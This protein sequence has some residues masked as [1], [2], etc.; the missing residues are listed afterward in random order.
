VWGLVEG[1]NIG[2]PPVM[3]FGHKSLRDRVARDCLTGEKVICLAIT[4]PYA[5]SDVAGLR[6]EAKKT[7]DGKHYIV[8][9]EKKWITNGVFADYF[10]VAVRTGGPGMGGISF[11]LLD[12]SMAGIT[13]KQMKCTGVWPSGTAYITLE[14]VK[15][16]VENLIGKEN[17]G[18]KY[19]VKN[20]NHERWGFVVQA[21]RF[22]RCCYEDAFRYAHKRKVFG[23]RLI[24]QPVI[25]YKFAQM[26]RHI[27]GTQNWLE[28]LTYQMTKMPYAE[29][30][31]VLAGPV[32]LLKA[33]ATQTFEYCAREA[34]QI[35]GGLSYTRGGQGEKVERLSR[36]VRAYS[37]PGGSEE[38]MLDLGVR[39]AMKQ[40]ELVSKL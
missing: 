11:L 22:A 15:V 19:I 17:E 16:P 25:R 14:D 4:E 9:G 27:E 8:N 38:I 5:G 40:Y 33:Q 37:I 28:E 10:T 23:Q 12:R 13:T 24:D 39:Q 6:A 1:L 3:N 35:F 29:A 32:A 20:F 21:N 31:T 30:A 36:E 7:A 18:F 2:L 34:A 26:T